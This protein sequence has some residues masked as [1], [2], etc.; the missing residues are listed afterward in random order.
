MLAGICRKKKI[1]PVKPKSKCKT[2]RGSGTTITWKLEK[3]KNHVYGKENFSINSCE[4]TIY[5][6]HVENKQRTK[7]N[8]VSL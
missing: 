4:S 5:I 2:S 3:K 8:Y 1:M 6:L 7:I